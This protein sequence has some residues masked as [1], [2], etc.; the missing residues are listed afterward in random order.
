[1]TD[2][3]RIAPPKHGE[4]YFDPPFSI[5]KEEALRNR[6]RTVKESPWGLSATKVREALKMPTDHPL[7]MSGHQPIFFHPGLWSKC[8]AAS[9]LAEAVQGTAYHKLTD[10][11]VSAEYSH[12][13]PEVEDN[14][15][16]RRKKL[17]FFTNHELQVMEKTTPYAFLPPPDY[18]AMDK[19]YTD[20]QVFCP[21]PVREN[22]KAFETKLLN[23]LRESETWNGYHIHNL[24]ML[25]EICQTQRRFL[26][27][28]RI[29]ASEPFFEFLTYW[30]ANL[31]E[32]TGVYNESLDD[33]RRK[34]GIKHKLNPMPNLGF[35]DW[36]FEIPFW[37]ITQYQQRH[38]LMAKNDGKHIVLKLRG[39]SGIYSADLT[40]LQNDLA[41]LPILIWPKAIPQT[42]F[43]RLYLCDF[44]IHGLGGGWYEEVNDLIFRKALKIKPLAYGVVSATYLVEP[45]ESQPLETITSH[46]KILEKW[47]RNLEK[48]PEYLFTRQEKWEKELPAFMHPV[49]KQCLENGH[50]EKLAG[51]K[52]KWV[53][54]LSDP[55]QRPD[56]S[57]K[58][59]E[60]NDELYDGCIE[61]VKILEVGLLD[62]SRVK[63]VKEVLSHREYP[64]F[65]FPKELFTQMKDKV[66]LEVDRS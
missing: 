8:L 10:T 3:E 30:M 38:S 14:G 19:I 32:L 5:W 16:A 45:E 24:K 18:A 56:A 63:E 33:Y 57:Q 35:E 31:P 41:T 34:Y 20:A 21:K 47:E 15:K 54:L 43:C 46:E 58:I 17:E 2:Y 36:W 60:I 11:A 44:F 23:G 26:E 27:G 29:W 37:G 39:T 40:T 6:E 7:V 51:E 12:F 28:S 53:A 9:S 52:K 50:L 64:F 13:L 48:N 4:F 59:K 65:C 55:A 22:M 66:R 42:L 49:F 25:D 62:V 1:M 61:A